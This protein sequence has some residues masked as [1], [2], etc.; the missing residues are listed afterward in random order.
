MQVLQIVLK[1]LQVSTSAEVLNEEPV[2][3]VAAHIE[4]SCFGFGAAFGFVARDDLRTLPE[5]CSRFMNVPFLLR[6]RVLL[7]AFWLNL[8]VETASFGWEGPVLLPV[9]GADEVSTTIG[10]RRVPD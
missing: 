4:H 6:G 9:S 7:V 3:F 1:C 5:L 8:P 10:S 2:I